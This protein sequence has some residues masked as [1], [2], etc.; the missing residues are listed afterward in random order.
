VQPVNVWISGESWR[1]FDHPRENKLM[2]TTSF[3]RAA[4]D[5]YVRG[6]TLGIVNPQAPKPIF[7]APAERF[8]GKTARAH[9]RITDGYELVAT[10]YEFR[11]ACF[12]KAPNG[13]E[14]P[15]K[16]TKEPG[17]EYPPDEVPD[18]HKN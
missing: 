10:Q 12:S 11:F 18:P 4:S 5:G 3:G 1:V 8:L 7:Q 14:T 17:A 15:S 13:A 9:C 2:V 16:L 6:A